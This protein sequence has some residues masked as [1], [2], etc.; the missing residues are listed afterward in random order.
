VN[1]GTQFPGHLPRLVDAIRPA[2][3]MAKKS[4]PENLL[5]AATVENVRYNMQRLT[6][7]TPIVAE[8]VAAGKVKIV[9]G[10]YDI[11]TGVVTLVT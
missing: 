3:E 6:E 7:A 8:A 11:A 5:A 4:A 9:G 2:V 1:D 10:V